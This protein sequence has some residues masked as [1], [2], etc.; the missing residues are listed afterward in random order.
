MDRVALITQSN[1]LPWR[2]YFSLI[3]EADV[4]VIFDSAQFTKRDWR[5]RNRIRVNGQPHWLTIPIKAGGS[6]SSSVSEI[7]VDDSDWIESHVN[8]IEQAYSKYPFH[9]DLAFILEALKSLKETSHLSQINETILT[10]ILSEL[11]ITTEIVRASTYDHSGT[12]SERLAMLAHSVKATRYLT[13]PAG[14]NYLDHAPFES[15]SIAVEFA[16]YGKLPPDYDG[17]IPG[18]EYSIIDLIARVGLREAK[19][20]VKFSL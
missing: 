1:Y 2:G 15:Y 19:N 16:Q 14:I 11:E 12:A 8:R 18:G 4:F 10:V 9:A 3:R 17:V 6:Q 5:N 20:L 7:V 13:A